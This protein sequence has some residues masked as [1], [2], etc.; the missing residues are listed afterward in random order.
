MERM[1]DVGG[2]GSGRPDV[3]VF[4]SGAER[5]ERNVNKATTDEIHRIGMK[6]CGI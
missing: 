4:A 1:A 6:I 5:A 3:I 2:V